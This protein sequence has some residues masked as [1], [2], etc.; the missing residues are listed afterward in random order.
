[1]TDAM[2]TEYSGFQL[3]VAKPKS[4]ELLWPMT[5]NVNSAMSQSE[6]ETNSCHWRQTQEN[7][8]EKSKLVRKG[9]RVYVN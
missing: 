8:R 6:H 5:A 1:M 9:G 7:T 3:S 4:N 2:K